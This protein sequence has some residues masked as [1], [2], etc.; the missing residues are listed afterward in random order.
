MGCLFQREREGH[1]L[2]NKFGYLNLILA[3]GQGT[4]SVLTRNAYEFDPMLKGSFKS[5]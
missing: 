3:M 5:I 4:K 2:V 1:I